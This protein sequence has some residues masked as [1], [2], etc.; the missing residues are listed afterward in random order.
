MFA[1]CC[2]QSQSTHKG[3][4]SQQLTDEMGH[5]NACKPVN[6]LHH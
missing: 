3:A 2:P 6:Q 1:R 5:R 4:F